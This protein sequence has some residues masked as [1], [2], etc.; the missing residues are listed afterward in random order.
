MSTQYGDD[1]VDLVPNSVD[2]TQFFAAV[3]G[4]QS[5]PTVG[6]LYS[7]ASFKGLDVSLAAL[8]IVRERFPDLRIDLLWQPATDGLNC[9]LPE[10][11]EFFLSPPQDQIP[12][13]LLSM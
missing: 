8:R 7:T 1:V 4:K 10:G 13:P 11:V 3:R 9:R 2:H 5:T 12:E 6:L